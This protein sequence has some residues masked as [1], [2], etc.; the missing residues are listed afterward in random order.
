MKKYFFLLSLLTCSTT[1]ETNAYT[2]TM[3]GDIAIGAEANYKKC[4][5]YVG[6][7][8]KTADAYIKLLEANAYEDAEK[9]AQENK[10]NQKKLKKC[11]KKEGKK[12]Y[13]PTG[14]TIGFGIGF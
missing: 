10:K 12:W 13:K 8:K 5:K 6:R 4:K 9:M 1:L 7:I 11:E 2:V 14:G 3:S